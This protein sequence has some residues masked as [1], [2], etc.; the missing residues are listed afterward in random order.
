MANVSRGGYCY[1]KSIGRTPL[2]YE[3]QDSFRVVVVVVF[4]RFF[5][6]FVCL[7]FFFSNPGGEENVVRSGIR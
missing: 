1:F 4:C 2:Y 7:L 6:S 5:F 3:D